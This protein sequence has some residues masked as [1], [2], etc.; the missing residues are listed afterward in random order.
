MHL[1][2]PLQK[3]VCRR[4]MMPLHRLKWIPSPGRRFASNCSPRAI[5]RSDT[6]CS[7]RLCP[8]QCPFFRALINRRPSSCSSSSAALLMFPYSSFSTVRP[9]SISSQSSSTFSSRNFTQSDTEAEEE[10]KF[11][12][13]IVHRREVLTPSRMKWDWDR[14]EMLASCSTPKSSQED[15][16]CHFRLLD[17]TSV[18]FRPQLSDNQQQRHGNNKQRQKR[19]KCQQKQQQLQIDYYFNAIRRPKHLR[20]AKRHSK[21]TER[22]FLDMEFDQLGKT[23][24]ALEEEKQQ[25]MDEE[26]CSSPILL[27]FRRNSAGSNETENFP[28]PP[29]SPAVGLNC[30]IFAPQLLP[31]PSDPSANNF[32]PSGRHYTVLRRIRMKHKMKREALMKRKS[33]SYGDEQTQQYTNLP[34]EP[35]GGSKGSDQNEKEGREEDD[36]GRKRTNCTSDSGM[37]EKLEDDDDRT[38]FVNI[39]AVE[40]VYENL[41]PISAPFPPLPPTSKLPN[42]HSLAIVLPQQFAEDFPAL[43][44]RLVAL[45]FLDA[46]N[47][48]RKNERGKNERESCS[49]ATAPFRRI[50]LAQKQISDLVG[51]KLSKA[52]EL[53]APTDSDEC[54]RRKCAEFC[55]QLAQKLRNTEAHSRREFGWQTKKLQKILHQLRTGGQSGE[56][57]LEGTLHKLFRRIFR[58]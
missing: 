10:K 22:A 3:S 54:F 49:S 7:S 27:D 39:S 4:A 19:A 14:R 33:E 16:L 36:N 58:K 25:Q 44:A 6:F 12:K 1:C 2:C 21:T 42:N 50:R 57:I 41:P 40:K 11:Q 29:A 34:M 48:S 45:A 31:R 20:G 32:S 8:F 9:H 56:G 51:L 24:M 52:T 23:E 26:K 30:K 13:R 46:R 37:E 38:Q 17:E 43:Y 5:P 47:E 55:S 18:Y 15:L 53:N 28:P 35:I